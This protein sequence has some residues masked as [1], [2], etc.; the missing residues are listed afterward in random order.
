M[1]DS[2]G[3][4]DFIV[5]HRIEMA[6]MILLSAVIINLLLKFKWTKKLI[7]DVIDDTLKVDDGKGVRRFS[8]TKITM[9]AAVGS[10]L[11][12]FHFD[13]ISNSKANETLFLIMAGI[14]TGVGI[15]KAF[16]KKLDPEVV[17]PGTE[18]TIKEAKTANSSETTIK[19][20]NIS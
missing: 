17:A 8:G 12:A 7:S 5:L 20:E 3:V 10:I 15:S 19:E 1:I 6:V 16:S 9:F 18:T 14:A 4:K 2:S 11:W 13:T